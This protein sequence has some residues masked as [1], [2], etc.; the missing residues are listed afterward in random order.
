MSVFHHLSLLTNGNRPNQIDER[1]VNGNSAWEQSSSVGLQ[2]AGAR[3][4]N[5]DIGL[6]CSI[7]SSNRI[8]G[9]NPE[10]TLKVPKN[11]CVYTHEIHFTS[12]NESNIKTLCNTYSVDFFEVGIELSRELAQ[13]FCQKDL[14]SLV[15]LA[16]VTR[17]LQPCYPNC[18]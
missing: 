14:I 10:L 7:L 11:V 1:M 8:G 2:A 9:S 3:C 12:E 13:T 6:W 15:A 16:V 5:R 17:L 18:E 4:T